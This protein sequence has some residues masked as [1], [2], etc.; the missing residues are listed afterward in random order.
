LPVPV[1]S[2]VAFA[3]LNAGY[4]SVCGRDV[5]NRLW[6]WGANGDYRLGIPYGNSM[7]NPISPG[8]PTLS[9]FADVVDLAGGSEHT[10]AVDKDGAV[11]CAGFNRRGQLGDGHRTSQGTPQLVPNLSNVTGLVAGAFHTCATLA[12]NSMKCWGQNNNGQLGN[13]SY[14]DS[15]VPVTVTAIDHVTAGGAGGDHTCVISSGAVYCWGYGNDGRLGDGTGASS[16]TAKLTNFNGSISKLKVTDHDTCVMVGM[17]PLCVG[18]QFGSTVVTPNGFT[19]V[20]DIATGGGH[21]CVVNTD[22][23]VTCVGS[24]L[25]GQLGD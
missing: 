14:A 2:P 20:L 25:Y 24:N 11:R 5:T 10:C 3:S 9:T 18:S 13:G 12:D 16:P 17:T 15:A 19:A 23:T 1:T 6:C 21:W 22:H 4:A 8:L 7:S